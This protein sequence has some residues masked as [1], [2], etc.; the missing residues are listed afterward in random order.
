MLEAALSPTKSV[1][2]LNDF[3]FLCTIGAVVKYWN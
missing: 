1:C 3:D 2:Y